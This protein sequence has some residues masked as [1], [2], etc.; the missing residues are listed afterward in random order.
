MSQDRTAEDGVRLTQQYLATML[1]VQR[2]TVTE[3][4]G[5][6]GDAGLIR[7]GRGRIDILDRPR[8][9]AES[10]ECYDT[11]RANLEQL[12]GRDPSRDDGAGGAPRGR[13]GS[14]R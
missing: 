11:V 3:A 13:T 4:L 7:Q 9:L 12:I 10:C 1:G 8:M 2:T 5:E 6:L 14:I